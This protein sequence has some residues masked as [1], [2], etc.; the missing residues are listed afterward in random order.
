MA[1]EYKIR[2]E[3]RGK[4]SEFGADS[5]T[6]LLLFLATELF[7]L[8]LQTS[9]ATVKNN[10]DAAAK[11]L[12]DEYYQH[13]V[14]A[15]NNRTRSPIAG[16]GLEVDLARCY[17]ARMAIDEVVNW[18]KRERNFKTS[19]TAVGRYWMRFAQLPTAARRA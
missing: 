1:N 10:V 19:Q 7:S 9:P 11:K 8:D 16:A 15:N 12:I 2:L 3:V 5:V 18:L 4:S 13:F 6:E 14:N 17:L